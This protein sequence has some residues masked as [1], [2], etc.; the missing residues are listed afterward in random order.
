MWKCETAKEIRI[1]II[2]ENKMV[3]F[4]NLEILIRNYNLRKVTKNEQVILNDIMRRE[5]W[6]Y[7]LK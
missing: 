5:S 2:I 7:N 4:R 1:K 6:N 3:T